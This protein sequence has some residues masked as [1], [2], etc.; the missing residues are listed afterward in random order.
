[1][2]K[3][4]SHKLS[5]PSDK[6]DQS[7]GIHA[8]SIRLKAYL[9]RHGYNGGKVKSSP[10]SASWLRQWRERCSSS[11]FSSSVS[12]SSLSWRM[13]SRRRWHSCSAL[14]TSSAERP[15]CKCTLTGCLKQE[16]TPLCGITG[17]LILCSLLCALPHRPQPQA[18]ESS[19]KSV[20][21][22]ASF[23]TLSGLPIAL[24]CSAQPHL[25]QLQ[26]FYGRRPC[27]LPQHNAVQ[28][29]GSSIMTTAQ[30]I[31]LDSGGAVLW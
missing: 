12:Y 30:D 17:S 13:L 22:I 18:A 27:R 5:L 24:T 14:N 6:A 11:V 10:G 25:A 31:S 26:S 9:E 3:V 19:G 16:K 21:P 28:M 15:A 29:C 1:M 23:S 20:G 4:Q 8:A 7:N 2:M